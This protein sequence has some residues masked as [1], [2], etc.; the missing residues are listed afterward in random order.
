MLPSKV[1]RKSRT[2]C[3]CSA[4]WPDSG[5]LYRPG[6]QAPAVNVQGP[7]TGTSDYYLQQVQQSPDDNKADWQLLAIRALLNEGKYPRANQQMSQ[8][9]QQLSDVQRLELQLL[10]AQLRL[11]GRDIATAQEILAKL[12][13]AAMSKDQQQR[14]YGLKIAAS[15]DAL[16]SI[17]CAR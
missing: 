7:A 13:P 4:G 8:L 17:W 6:P 9:P 2:L 11:G 15:R 14:Y 10:T 3:A 12:D 1:V 16:R 5:G